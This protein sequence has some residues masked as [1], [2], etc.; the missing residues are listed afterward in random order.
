M[1]VPCPRDSR[2]WQAAPAS[3]AARSGCCRAAASAANASRPRAMPSRCPP[4]WFSRSASARLS[5]AWSKSPLVTAIQPMPGLAAGDLRPGVELAED[6]HGVGVVPDRHLGVAAGPGQGAHPV[7]DLR[8]APAVV[9]GQHLQRGLVRPLGRLQLAL[10]DGD[11]RLGGLGQPGLPV[12]ARRLGRRDR[13]LDVGH[14]VAG[15]A[16]PRRRLADHPQRGRHREVVAAGPGSAPGSR[17][18][19]APACRSPA[20]RRRSPRGPPGPARAPAGT[21]PRRAG[22]GTG[23]ARW[24]PR[25]RRRAAA[26]CCAA[27]CTAAG[28]RRRGRAPARSA[29]AM[30][31]LPYSAMPRRNTARRTGQGGSPRLNI[32]ADRLLHQRQDAVPVPQRQR[33]CL[34]GGL[35]PLGGVLPDRVQQPVPGVARRL[36]VQHHQRLVDQRDE[37]PEHRVGR[38][39]ASSEHTCSAMSRFQPEKTASRRSSICSASSSSS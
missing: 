36:A 28:P 13:L 24:P 27:R 15:P 29:S 18:R 31:K 14:R 23:P 22:R 33:A 5:C 34:P 6:L 26:T 19:S 20:G 12:V 35:Q 17:S 39:M 16:R 32:V 11:G 4:T 1:P 8:D 3:R 7:L 10:P 37:Q 2:S 38:A 25:G 21:P 30:R 9:V